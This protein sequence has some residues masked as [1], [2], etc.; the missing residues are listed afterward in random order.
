MGLI[1]ILAW[2]YSTPELDELFQILNSIKGFKLHNHKGATQQLDD[3]SES[4]TD[5]RKGDVLVL[6]C[7]DMPTEVHMIHHLKN[8]VIWYTL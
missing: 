5:G 7:L 1:L 3:W 4:N 8:G 2:M 6:Y